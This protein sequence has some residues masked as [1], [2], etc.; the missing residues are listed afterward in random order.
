[1]QSKVNKIVL[2]G[3]CGFLGIET[4]KLLKLNKFDVLIIDLPTNKFKCPEGIKF[5]GLNLLD[6]SFKDNINLEKNDIIVNLASRQYLNNI[7]YM[8][9][10]KWFDEINLEVANILLD[11]SIKKKAF[12]YIFFS[13]DM[14][15]GKINTIP[16]KENYKINPIAE[17]GLSKAKSEN[18]LINN[19]KNKIPLTIFRPRLISGPGRLGVFKNLFNLI[20]KSLPVPIIGK[21]NNCYQMVSVFDCAKATL[22]AIDKNIPSEIFNLASNDSIAVH[23]LMENLIDHAHSKSKILKI[24]SK[25]IKPILF[26]FDLL[27]KTILYKE[28]YSIAD[29]NITLDISK[30]KKLL[31]WDPEFNDQQMIN[32]AYDFW[33]KND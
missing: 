10:Q 16:V 18:L 4:A 24:N 31:D 12:G 25:I 13:T 8:N 23:K 2:I 33:L 22:K 15:Y 21:G 1:M 29:K 3:G 32:E 30:A 28:Q 26:T 7:P 19:A 9:R 17:Y 27:G 11:L 5:Q 20:K 14:V 6:N